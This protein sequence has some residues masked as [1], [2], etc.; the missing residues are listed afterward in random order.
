MICCSANRLF[1]MPVILHRDGPHF[2]SAG[3]AVGV[4][5]NFATPPEADLG[6]FR[7]LPEQ[8]QNDLADQGDVSGAVV[9]ADL[10][11][12]FAEND[13]QSPMQPVL[14]TPVL[15]HGSM[16]PLV[17]EFG[18]TDVVASLKDLPLFALDAKRD[19]PA[20]SLRVGPC[21]DKSLIVSVYFGQFTTWAFVR[22]PCG[23]ISGLD[24]D[25]S[26]VVGS[27]GF[28]GKSSD[29]IEITRKPHDAITNT[30]AAGLTKKTNNTD[31][32]PG[33]VTCSRRAIS[34]MAD[35]APVLPLPC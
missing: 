19:D 30:V 2:Q 21:A 14:D 23:E 11:G 15:A 34:G 29:T 1:I 6:P 25:R 8:I 28:V 17:S 9:L 10:D 26:N 22:L 35:N 16:E 4:Q 20:H 13:I 12:V 31:Q 24:A 18:R 27:D 5:V 33:G 32:L 7:V 3:T